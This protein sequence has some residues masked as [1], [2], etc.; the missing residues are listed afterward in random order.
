MI[1]SNDSIEGFRLHGKP[2][3]QFFVALLQI[4]FVVFI[5]R[6]II[7]LQHFVN[8]RYEQKKLERRNRINLSL[9]GYY[10]VMKHKNLQSGFSAGWTGIE[11]VSRDSKKPILRIKAK[12]GLSKD[13]FIRKIQRRYRAI[14]F[15][16]IILPVIN[17]LINLIY[18]IE[19]T[20]PIDLPL[21]P[22]WLEH[23]QS[24]IKWLERLWQIP[25]LAFFLCIVEIFVVGYIYFRLFG[26]PFITTND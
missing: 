11:R 18:I 16:M 19:F 14:S 13:D 15:L 1:F 8:R 7:D 4:I 21:P 20:I 2:F 6:E 10:W 9:G 26:I 17:L 12:D 22:L 3:V 25:E 24:I 23:I 5:W